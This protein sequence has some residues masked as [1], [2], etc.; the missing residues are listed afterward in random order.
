[1]EIPADDTLQFTETS[2]ATVFYLR[3][4]PTDLQG[5]LDAGSLLVAQPELNFLLN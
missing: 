3:V 2:A 5:N 1:V 4:S